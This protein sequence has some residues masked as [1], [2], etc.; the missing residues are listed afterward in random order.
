MELNRLLAYNQN[1]LT[2]NVVVRTTF[3]VG[4]GMRAL[5]HTSLALPKSV[6]RISNTTGYPDSHPLV[7]LSHGQLNSHF[8][9]ECTQILCTSVEEDI[10][11]DSPSRN[12][13]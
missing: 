7:G 8:R 5:M 12:T 9:E 13:R 11:R 3:S 2:T 6:V 10:I 4:V 1:Q